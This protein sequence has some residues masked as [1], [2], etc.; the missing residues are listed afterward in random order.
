MSDDKRCGTCRW[1]ESVG[2][3]GG[4]ERGE[5]GM[6]K[7]AIDGLPSSASASALLMGK[8]GGTTCSCWEAKE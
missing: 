7:S 4:I 5:C 2:M 8:D 6:V 3:K 1:W